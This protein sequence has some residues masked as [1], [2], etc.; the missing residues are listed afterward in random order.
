VKFAEDVLGA[1]T[2][3]ADEDFAAMRLNGADFMLHADHTY[4]DNPVSGLIQGLEG[5]GAGVE[6]RVYGCDPDQAEARA[7][8]GGWTVLTGTLDKPHGLRECVI[9]DDDGYCWVPGIPIASDQ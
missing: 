3:Y 2:T 6:L 9:L 4:E 1:T 8:E 7:R 5:R